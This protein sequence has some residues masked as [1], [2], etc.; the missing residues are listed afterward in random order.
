MF[1]LCVVTEDKKAKCKTMKTK[2]QVRMNYRG[3]N[4]AKK[5]RWGRDFPHLSRPSLGP[6][7]PPI[8]E[9]QGLFPGGKEA[10]AWH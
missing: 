1:V 7:Q 10:G 3:K 4:I 5:S 6:I 2:T 8:K 9:V